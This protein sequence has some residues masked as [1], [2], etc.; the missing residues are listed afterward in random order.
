VTVND[1]R[2]GSGRPVRRRGGRT[3]ALVAAAAVAGLLAAAF[4]WWRVP[5][6]PRTVAE[7]ARLVEQANVAIGQLENQDLDAAEPLLERLA[8][9]LPGDAFAP[10]N[11]AVAAVL[12]LTAGPPEARLL[13]AAAQRLDTLRRVE[14]ETR[15]GRWL[16]AL[17]ALAAEDGATAAARFAEIAA[18][19]PADAA[20]WYGLWRAGEAGDRAASARDLAPLERALEAAPRNVWLAIAWMRGMAG[21][22]EADGGP[23][24]LAAAI[25]SRWPAV[26]PFAPAVATFARADLRALLDEAVAA[27]GR[28]E[29]A[30]V[31]GRLRAVANLVAPQ[32]EADRRAVD[33]HPLEF[34]R[35]GLAPELLTRFGLGRP[36]ALAAIPV[37]FVVGN[38]PGLGMEHD[39]DAAGVA[40]H[41]ATGAVA[42]AFEDVDLDGAPDIVAAFDAAVR[43]W[44]RRDGRWQLLCEADVPAG[45]AG[46]LVADL[47]LDFDQP[48]VAG[49]AVRPEPDDA[50]PRAGGDRGAPSRRACPAADLDLLVY[51]AGGITCLENVRTAAGARLLRPFDGARPATGPIDAATL[52]DLDADGRLD[53]VV[54]D[55]AGLRVLTNLGSAGFRAAEP[56][57]SSA[58]LGDVRGMVAVDLDR[59]VDVDVVLV[60]TAGCG[61]LENLRHGQFRLVPLPAPAGAA[62]VEI[63]D[64]DADGAWDILV[65]GPTGVARVATRRTPGGTLDAA[66]PTVIAAGAVTGLVAFDYD[67]DGTLDLAVTGDDGLR[68]LRGAPDGGFAG[69]DAALPA[70]ER[71]AVGR[72]DVGDDDGDG[73]LDL[74]VVTPAGIATFVNEGGSAHHWLAVDLEA[75]QV[76][77]AGFAPSGRVNAHGLGSLLELR[78]GGSYQPR[79]VR[80]RT[81]HFGLGTRDAADV[82]RVLWLNGVPQNIIAPPVDV[83]VCEQQVL[84]GSC[85]YLYAW[86]GRE[87][88]FVTDLLWGAPLGLQRR[89]GELMPAR[90]WEHLLVPGEQLAPRDGGYELRVTEELWEAAYFDE[91]RLT[92]VD[93]PADVRVVSN[94]KV[95]PAEIAAFGVHTVRLPRAPV[96]ARDDRGGDVLAAI[97]AEDGVYPPTAARAVRQ[98][99]LEPHALELDPGPV[100]AGARVTL[101]LTGWTYPTTVGLNLALDRDPRLGVPV[102]PALAVPDGAGGWRTVLPFMGFPGG[103]TKSIALDLTGLV[104]PEDPRVRIETSMDIRWDHACFAIGE[105]PAEVRL[106]DLALLAAD[107]HPRGFSRVVRDGSDGPERFVYGDV[108]TAAKWPPMLGGFTRFGDVRDLVANPDDRLV[109]M[110]A[111]DEM[112]LRFAAGPPCPPGWRRDFLFTSVGWDKDAN[113]ATAEGQSVEPLPFRSMRSYPPGP[114]D[115]PPDAAA[116][117]EAV[118]RY[119]TRVQG[120]GFWRAPLRGGRAAPRDGG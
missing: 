40:Q 120:D 10:R 83:V 13:G 79:V 112:T 34:V 46:L 37:R 53:L 1:P 64:V 55:A 105:E 52:A 19:D 85:P 8:A 86:D 84:L 81:T 47:D 22:V 30:L 4:A 43:V 6:G 119:Q 89:E 109:V 61:W 77:G 70:G 15:A 32:S 41:P 75:Q 115:R 27:A 95:G 57:V 71:G 35:E 69:A 17:A 66:P 118:R 88:V 25:E 98:G 100:P 67:N 76:K 114:D 73:D 116:V 11:L 74:V 21:R 42:V 23:D 62:A 92:A 93:H 107:L 20:G 103:K 101:I 54:A 90:S 12:R 110:A 45:T 2:D 68:L 29:W 18:A 111:G 96:A 28:G 80:R 49:Q 58:E 51:G 26:A 63:V 117:Q 82:V 97:V 72:L 14:G 94:E 104:V 31:S 99:L 44:S 9:A 48:R 36:P 108:S 3:R 50:G 87:H 5:R 56:V 39:A 91:V 65:G 60:G 38:G 78:A 16:R 33:P 113:L 24:G 59:D 102:P 7:A 106:H